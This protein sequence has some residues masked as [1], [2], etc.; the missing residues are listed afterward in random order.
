[1]NLLKQLYRLLISRRFALVLLIAIGTLLLLSI[2]LPNLSYH[3]PSEM[4]VFAK[5]HPILY[6]LGKTFNPP[7]LASSYTFIALNF[8]L[9]LSTLLCSIERLRNREFKDPYGKEVKFFKHRYVMQ[10]KGEAQNVRLKTEAVLKKRFWSLTKRLKRKDTLFLQAKKGKIGFWGSITFHLGFIFILIGVVVSALTRFS[11]TILIT[12]GQELP[13]SKD[14]FTEIYKDAKVNFNFPAATI[15]LANFKPTIVK[16]R[17]PTD[18]DAYVSFVNLENGQVQNNII[19]VNK[20]KKFGE[21]IIL[22][23]NYGFAPSWRLVDGSGKV[24]LNAYV[25]LRGREYGSRDSFEVPGSNI[26]VA[27]VWYPNYSNSSSIAPK[28]PVFNITVKNKGRLLYQGII[29]QGQ[30]VKFKGYQLTFNDVRH[31]AYLQVSRDKGLAVIFWAFV[32]SS[33]GLAVRFISHDRQI[34]VRI[35]PVNTKEVEVFISGRS[36]YFPVLFREELEK[37]GRA[38]AKVIQG[39]DLT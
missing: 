9:I 36:R 19:G 4:A 13:F 21:F 34:S 31:W 16:E 20:A 2:L 28:E 15:S 5:K 29:R 3:E 8:V 26:T 23:Q 24:L 39:G 22:L 12:E 17:F 37:I 35:K 27:T 11:G 6:Q 14:S 7:D 30:T 25:N 33:L 38:T 32:I 18:Y 1:M 10:V